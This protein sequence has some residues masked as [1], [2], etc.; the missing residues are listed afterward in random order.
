[1]SWTLI[2]NPDCR[3]APSPPWW[4]CK[5]DLSGEGMF[6]WSASTVLMLHSVA[7]RTC[8]SPAIGCDPDAV[9]NSALLPWGR[10]I[11][12]SLIFKDGGCD[13]S[14][15]VKIE[16]SERSHPSALRATPLE[17]E[18][19]SVRIRAFAVDAPLEQSHNFPQK[20]IRDCFVAS[21]LR[22]DNL[23]RIRGLVA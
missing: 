4:R 10:R 19:N 9:W 14:Y 7:V 23:I 21:L 12:K 1:M 15:R 22:N 17:G 11:W 5:T 2:R 6:I 3:L 16:W 18:R 13:L 20:Q 8:D